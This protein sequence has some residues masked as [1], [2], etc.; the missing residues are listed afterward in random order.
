M[1]NDKYLLGFLNGKGFVTSD[2]NEA[3]QLWIGAQTLDELREYEIFKDGNVNVKK[4][5]EAIL[6]C[7]E[8][9]KSPDEEDD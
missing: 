7:A 5:R 9:D 3:I 6:R 8:E 1:N 4:A 2:V